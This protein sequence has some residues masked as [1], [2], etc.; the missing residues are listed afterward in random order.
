MTTQEIKEKAI[1]IKEKAMEIETIMA[2][3]Y[4]KTGIGQL[5]IVSDLVESWTEEEAESVAKYLKKG[6]HVAV[7]GNMK[8]DEYQ[9]KDGNNRRA[10]KV[11]VYQLDF[12]SPMI[13]EGSEDVS[14]Q[15]ENETTRNH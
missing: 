14:E 7:E 12:V 5:P 3:M 6:L 11:V 1:E 15:K 8:C 13:S 10:W 9:D 4:G 2:E